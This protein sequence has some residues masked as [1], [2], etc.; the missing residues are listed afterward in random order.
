MPST[1]RTLPE[2]RRLAEEIFERQIRSS[3]QPADDGK[4]VAID[5]DTGD[6]EID[7]DDYAAIMRLKSRRA[8][9]DTWLMRAGY[10]TAYQI[11]AVR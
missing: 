9:A 3:L 4:F 10:P 2:L 1:K 5:V 7:A 11:R 6:Y 8:S